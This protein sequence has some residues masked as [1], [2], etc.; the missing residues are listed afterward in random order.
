[1][2]DKL[3]SIGKQSTESVESVVE[4]VHSEVRYSV[5]GQCH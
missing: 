1:M 2:V 3:R 5:C 4:K